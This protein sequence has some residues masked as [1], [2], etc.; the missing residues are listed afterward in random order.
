MSTWYYYNEQG[1]KIETTGG[2]LKGLAKAGMIT[3]E[4]IVENEEGKKAPARKVKGLTFATAATPESAPPVETES[5]GIAQPVPVHEPPVEV[6]PFAVATPEE[7][8]PFAVAASPVTKPIEINPFAV[9][10]PTVKQEVPRQVATPVAGEYEDFTES[11]AHRFKPI[12]VFAGIGILLLVLVLIGVGISYSGGSRVTF[13]AAE[14]REIDEFVAEFGNNVRAT[15]ETYGTL[16]H[17]AAI[18]GYLPVVKYLV[19]RG[20]DV[21][22]KCEHGQTPLHAATHRSGQIEIVRF[23]VSQGANVRAKTMMATLRLTWQKS[24]G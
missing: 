5:Y 17:R 21:N 19:S 8:N 9:S 12:H 20:A 3:P 13:T 22:A 1:E 16:L 14:Q 24:T 2:R 18:F 7:I 23:L 10:T 6:N 15:D 11:P 4:T